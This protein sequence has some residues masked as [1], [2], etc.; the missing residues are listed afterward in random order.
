MRFVS[1]IILLLLAFAPPAQAAATGTCQI[2]QA[3]FSLRCWVPIGAATQFT[4]DPVFAVFATTRRLVEGTGIT[5]DVIA[6]DCAHRREQR[7]TVPMGPGNTAQLARFNWPTALMD[8]PRRCV[9]VLFNRC[10]SPQ[11]G[12]ARCSQVLSS[13]GSTA[14]VEW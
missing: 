11:D 4:G 3:S 10:L 13:S 2:Q 6:T 14:R 9:E 8:A 12:K 5:M 1:P 7:A